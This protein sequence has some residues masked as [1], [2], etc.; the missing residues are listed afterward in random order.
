[1]ADRRTDLPTAIQEL[2]RDGDSVVLGAC[3]ETAIPFA[4]TF[5]II[6]QEKRDLEM[7]APISDGAT[8]ML[9]GAGCVAHV[10]GAWVGNVSGGLGHNY[11]RAFEAGVPR[12]L[13][14][15]DHS[16]FSLGMA[17]LAGAYGLPFVPIR[18]LLGSD[19]PASNPALR[20]IADPLNP[21]QE[22]IAVPPLRPAVAILA[23]QR[24]DAGGNAHFWGSS[25]LAVEAALAAERVILLADEIV[26]ESVIAS[27]P[28]R[29]LFPGFR[30][31]A[32]VAAPAGTHP[33]P[34]TGRWRRDT[35]FFGDYHRQ[36]RER[37]GFRAWLREWV[38]DVG[39]H[40][41]YRAK[42]GPR[43][44]ALRIRG[45]ALAAPANYAAE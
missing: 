13:T 18:S 12:A 31:T 27:D 5:E 11:R 10:T 24:A 25:G 20:R 8:D 35:D 2:V 4:A 38:L 37:E 19:I 34:L 1:M 14:V 15:A 29:V 6:R 36:S 43:L 30:T 16:N 23:V 42:L 39:D 40:A 17:L 7:I 26:P 9:I 44:D 32:V 22:V 33:A 45:E 21:G 3:L 28:S 41:G